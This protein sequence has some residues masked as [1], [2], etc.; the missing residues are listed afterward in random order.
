MSCTW[1][2]SY[3]AVGSHRMRLKPEDG[4]IFISCTWEVL[5]D[6]PVQVWPLGPARQ[7]FSFLPE[8][9]GILCQPWTLVEI[10][11]HLCDGGSK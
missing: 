2:A 8:Q 7:H 3:V 6:S 5:A 1:L 4:Q 11:C 10:F 9:F